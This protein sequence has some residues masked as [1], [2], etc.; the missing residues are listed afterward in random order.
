MWPIENFGVV[1][2]FTSVMVS[3]SPG[4]AEISVT[5]NFIVSLPA[6]SMGGRRGQVAAGVVAD[7]A[8]LSRADVSV[9]AGLEQPPPSAANVRAK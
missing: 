3:F 9:A 2:R 6:I 1:P 4:L 5:L 8:A 7:A